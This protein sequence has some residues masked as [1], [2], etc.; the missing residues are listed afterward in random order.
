MNPAQLRIEKASPAD[1]PLILSFIR[2]LAEYERKAHEV[3]S[4]EADLR[5]ALF[6]DRPFVEVLLAYLGSEPAGFALYF[7]I[8]STFRGKPGLYLEDLFVEPPY[9]GRKIGLALLKELAAVARAR[10]SNRVEWQVLKWNQP[11]IDFYL[12]LGAEEIAEWGVYRL[13]GEA[14]KRL[15]ERTE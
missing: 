1:I 9:R 2:K 13:Q 15:A 8:F 14:L 12:R 3:V 7:W 4:T 6:G 10:G 11:A 5:D